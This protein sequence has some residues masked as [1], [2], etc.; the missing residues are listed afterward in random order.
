MF[1]FIAR[2]LIISV[3]VLFGISILLFA[4]LRWMPGDPTEALLDPLSFTGDREAALIDLR[5]RLGLDRSLIVQYF[6]WLREVLQGNLG[7]SYVDGRPVTEILGDRLGA[8]ARL[9][10]ASVIIGLLVGVPLGIVA[11]MRKN[12]MVD[13]VSS[14]GSLLMIS[15]PSFFTALVGIYVFGIKLGWLPT[16][17][18]NTPGQT[19]LLDS[20]KHL[21]LP[22]SILGLSLAGPY[23]RYVRSSLL[24]VLSQDFL[25][26]AR[27]KG[28]T[29]RRVVV[30]HALAN[31]LIPLIT[32]MAVQLPALFGG[33]VVIEQMFAW[34]GMGRMALD[35]VNARNYP[36]ILGFVM[37]VAILV[38]LSN[39]A[40]D[41]M[42]AIV[43]PRVR[44]GQEES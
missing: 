24:E 33:A 8:T 2:R 27:S 19:G 43:D 16:S 1:A 39:L 32:V 13:Y 18:Q 23:M 7:Y 41:V 34:P 17:G 6:S 9:M 36:I 40:A 4:M 11:A 20:L 25:V 30:R 26:T 44:L 35:A 12:S 28:L 31:A 3:L 42:Y 5:R 29:R 38:L 14:A 37:F 21:I 10:T 22:A 15:V